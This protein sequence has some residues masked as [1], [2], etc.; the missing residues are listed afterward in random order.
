GQRRAGPSDFGIVPP[1][2]ALP[3]GPAGT[4]HVRVLP[5]GEYACYPPEARDEFWRQAWQIAPQSDR[6]GF[7]LFGRPL[8][9]LAPLEMRSHGIV[10]GVVQVPPSGQPI[11]QMVDAQPSGG[12]PKFGTV[13]RADLWR[14]AQ[15][16]LGSRLTFQR[17]DY[18]QA[19]QALDANIAWLARLARQMAAQRRAGAAA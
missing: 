7:R 13:I 2:V 16:P 3:L 5:A 9:P 1:E 18:D 6:Y 8:L 14:L 4:T 10:P 11:I 17:V 12:Y 19:V 15:A